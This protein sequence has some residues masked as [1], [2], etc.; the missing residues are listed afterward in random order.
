MSTWKMK[1]GN[2]HLLF[3]E[4]NRNI[5]E[6]QK[7]CYCFFEKATQIDRYIHT[8]TERER[9]SPWEHTSIYNMQNIW[10]K[11]RNF[12]NTFRFTSLWGI[13]KIG[14]NG[15][16]LGWEFEISR[17]MFLSYWFSCCLLI[18]LLGHFP[19]QGS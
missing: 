7:D 5:N 15:D 16:N 3:S 14:D 18:C 6:Y 12:K 17:F 2:K 10:T 11:N 9:E 8:Y 13:F 4:C 1:S 19:Y